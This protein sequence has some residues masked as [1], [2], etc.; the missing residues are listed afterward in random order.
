VGAKTG[1]DQI[2]LETVATNRGIPM[3]VFAGEEEAMGWLN[4]HRQNTE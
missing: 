2:F 3:K 4:R 1:E